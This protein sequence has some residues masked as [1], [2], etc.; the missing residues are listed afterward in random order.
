MFIS[1]RKNGYY[2]LFFQDDI[3]G[4]R[5]MISCKSKRKSEALKFLKGYNNSQHSSKNVN[6]L[7]T[8]SQLQGEVMKYVTDNL[9]YSTTLFYKRVFN[10]LLRIIGDKHLKLITTK[11]IESYKSKRLEE[12][13]PSTVNIDLTT[14]KTIFNIAIRFNL[15]LSNPVNHIKKIKIDEKERL[16]FNSEEVSILLSGIDNKDL[17]NIVSFALKTGCRLNEILNIQISD[18]NFTDSTIAIKNKDDFKTKTGKVR[19]IPITNELKGLLVSIIG[20]EG[21]VFPFKN[22]DSY[23][24]NKKGYKFNKEF[25][26]KSF[27]KNLRRLGFPEKY[28]FHCLRHTYI[29]NLIKSGVNI[30][31]V[32]ALAGHTDIKTTERYIHLSTDDLRRALES[33]L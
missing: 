24:F 17:R 32:K 31:Y 25:I 7:L 28:H 2:Y 10:D 22:T 6:F 16:A 27:K 14:I 1:K 23:L 18:I 29:T 30:N 3:S 21:N 8:V 11:D 12:V 5:K 19:F 33:N 26:S 9:R 20:V 13:S 4:K 15:L